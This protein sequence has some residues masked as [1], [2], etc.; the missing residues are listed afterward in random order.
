MAMG[1]IL[2]NYMSNY[3]GAVLS[4]TSNFWIS[5]CL[6]WP[7]WAM[8]RVAG[9]ILIAIGLTSIVFAKW[10]LSETEGRKF[11]APLSAGA[12]LVF[13]DVLLKWLLA[14]YW[15]EWLAQFFVK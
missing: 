4:H 12:L 1:A 2:M 10:G 6:A 9:F 7:V 3:V 8:L 13:A 5:L 11:L 14:P 15:S